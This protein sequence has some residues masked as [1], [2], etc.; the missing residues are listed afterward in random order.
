MG[1]RQL[2]AAADV[3]V[4]ASRPRALEQMEI[5][6]ASSEATRDEFLQLL[7]TQVRN[8]DPLEPIKQQ[9]FLS[10]LAQFST[11]EGIENLNANFSAML[12][13]QELTQGAELLGRTAVYTD[14]GDSAE[15][16]EGVIEGVKF[17]NNELLLDINDSTVPISFVERLVL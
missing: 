17:E 7:V 3:V 14:G 16:S 11:L 1:L 9:D 15:L 8:Q 2:L 6:A 13:L 10:Q 12:Q 5:N 4:E